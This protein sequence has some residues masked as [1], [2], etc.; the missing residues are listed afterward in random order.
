MT[1]RESG[2]RQPVVPRAG[3]W[4]RID[5]LRRRWRTAS[6]A[7]GWPFPNDWSLPEV[8]HVCLA[9]VAEHDLV[10]SLRRLAGARA[11]AGAG[12]AETLGD[13]AALHAAL[14][15]AETLPDSDG[16][17]GVDPDAP[18]THL[19]RPMAIAWA[20]AAVDGRG[21]ASVTDGLTG[22]ATPAYLRRRLG[23]EYRGPRRAPMPVLVTFRLDLAGA[24]GWSRL[25]AMVLLADVL[26]AIFDTGETLVSL[27]PS[28]VAVL[29]PG[30]EGLRSRTEGAARL[31][32]SRLAADPQL[33]DV[34]GPDAS[35]HELPATHPEACALLT[36]LSRT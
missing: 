13:L 15:C 27:G 36:R 35:Y 3:E 7:S 5:S 26:C 20:D 31:A 32:A 21:S 28:V 22:L 23:E 18:P 1:S 6:M 8:E 16:L 24:T 33:R 30:G 14:T 12:L 11:K 19:L 10:P 4:Q 2:S 9:A 29:V 34:S 17:V 25:V